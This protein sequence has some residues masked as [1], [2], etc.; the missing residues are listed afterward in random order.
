MISN[1]GSFDSL[2]RIEAVVQSKTVH[3]KFSPFT[4]FDR[5]TVSVS[6][7]LMGDAALMIS[8]YPEFPAD[9]MSSLASQGEFI[10]VVDR[11]GSMDCSMHHGNDA[12]MRIESARVRFTVSDMMH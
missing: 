11:S 3:T 7:S 8:L 2:C 4:P 1:S 9:V 5:S 10:F 6:G 12:Q